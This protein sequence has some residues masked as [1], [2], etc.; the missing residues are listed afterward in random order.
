MIPESPVRRGKVPADICRDG[1]T[2]GLGN[3]RQSRCRRQQDHESREIPAKRPP[4]QR[5]DDSRLHPMLWKLCYSCNSHSSNELAIGVAAHAGV[6]A[7]PG[8]W[9]CGTGT[10]RGSASPPTPN[11]SG[12]S[13]PPWAG[14]RLCGARRLR[15]R[16][17]LDRP[18]EAGQATRFLDLW[19][20]AFD[21]AT[22][23]MRPGRYF[24][25]AHTHYSLLVPAAEPPWRFSSRLA[26]GAARFVQK[27]DRFFGYGAAPALQL[28][29]PPW[30]EARARGMA[31]GR[32]DGV[33]N[34]VMLETPR[35]SLRR[36]PG[37][38]AEIVRAV[39]RH[40]FGQPRR[41]ARQRRLQAPAT[42]YLDA[43][44]A[45]RAER[46]QARS[47]TISGSG[48]AD[49]PDAV[50]LNGECWTAWLTYDDSRGPTRS[51]PIPPAIVL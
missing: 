45:Q 25:A 7:A 33:N 37:R 9:W 14:H 30:D 5:P 16:P 42:V 20:A 47:L 15:H 24:E 34:E 12:G 36:P 17:R 35:L 39:M 10:C 48:L 28:R 40:H 46:P 43:C 50:R 29:E 1:L 32:F 49:L 19:R 11:A 51:A 8:P 38:S 21:P 41:T 27:L 4:H 2:P 3:R 44:A 23:M 6:P 13:S 18:G 31:L 22:G 26:G